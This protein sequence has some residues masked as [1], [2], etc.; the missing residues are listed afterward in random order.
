MAKAPEVEWL[1]GGEPREV[2]LEA[3]R[4]SFYGYALK[5]HKDD[6]GNMRILREGFIPTRGWG[7]YMEMR[8]GKTPTALNEFMLFRQGYDF[9]RIIVLGPNQYKEDWALENEKY[10][11]DV[12]MIPYYQQK[13]SKMEK[14]F[15]DAKGALSFSVNYEALQYD[16]TLDFLESIMTKRTLLVADESIFIKNR[17]SL[18]TKGA[19][20]IRDKVAVTRVASGLPMTQGPTDFFSQ[21][22]FIGMY[23]GLSYYAFRGKY[24]VMGGFKGRKVTGS[25]DEDKLN[26]DINSK[27]FVAK[28]RDWGTQSEAEHYQMRL[29]MAPEQKK[30]Y[31]EM[32]QELITIVE[33]E[34]GEEEAIIAE[35]VMG[36]LMKMQQI[37]SGFVY[38]EAGEAVEIM[39]PKK[40]P[41]MKALLM[42]L[43]NEIKGKVVIPYHYAQSG[44]LLEEVLAK[45]NPA[46]ILSTGRMKKKGLDY[47]SEKKKFN[48]DPS[49]RV[50]IGN[51][52]TMK[53]GHDLTGSP[54]DRCATMFFFE[55]N[56]SLDN[57]T[58][59]EAR[60]T[61]A[62]QDW[63]NLYLDP[64]CSQTE[65]NAISALVEKR[66]LVEGVLGPYRLDRRDGVEWTGRQ[67]S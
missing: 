14:A 21:A 16:K 58:Q 65:L 46:F 54:E 51:L 4:R 33:T 43:E 37:S 28:R 62:F 42:L 32:N 26:A 49:C 7:H 1:I 48:N 11:V 44:E 5:D 66:N 20:Q 35:Q 36:K 6:E 23:D 56:F 45:Y 63:A 50:V 29:D 13:L 34:K 22:K 31:D 12:P 40:T 52:V 64:Y 67:Q 25:K 27:A 19:M 39:D 17:E 2:Q 57:R 24:C 41:K 30:H 61:T 59:V 18:F 53:Y 38:T 60:N 55:N 3:L 8:L 47:V 10:G 15:K 9:E